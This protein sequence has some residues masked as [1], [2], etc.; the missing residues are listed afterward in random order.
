MLYRK[1]LSDAIIENSLML[2]NSLLFVL[3]ELLKNGNLPVFAT[4]SAA[5]SIVSAI[6]TYY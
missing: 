3:V 6:M 2:H 1:R 4:F 5:F